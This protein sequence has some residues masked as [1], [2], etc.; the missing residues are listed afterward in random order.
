[1]SILEDLTSKDSHRIW[2][3]ACEVRNLRDRGELARLASHLDE[4]RESTRLVPLGGALRAN[5][6]HL[7][8]AIRKLQFVVDSSDCLCALY[9][10][11]DLY[12]PE[13]EKTAG[14]VRIIGTV[15]TGEKWVDH[16]ECECIDCGARFRVEEREYHYTWWSWKRT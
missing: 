7:T 9:E 10:M 11:D 16:Y 12:N 4:I 6:S 8:F 14:H 5:S 1:M 15:L 3:G 13:T 2:S